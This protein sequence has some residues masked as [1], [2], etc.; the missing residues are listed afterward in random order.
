M[1]LI[2]KE[3]EC[4]S[5]LSVEAINRVIREAVL[6]LPLHMEKCLTVFHFVSLRQAERK[7]KS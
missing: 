1:P 3:V 2:K 5:T 7:A 4:P 6:I